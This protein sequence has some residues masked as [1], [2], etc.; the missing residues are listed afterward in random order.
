MIRFVDIRSQGTG[1]R[2][3]FWDTTR[4]QFCTFANDQAWETRK[5]FIESFD[6]SGGNF[7]DAVSV[8]G[9]DRFNNLMPDWTDIDPT[10][11][12]L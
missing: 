8:S 7:A 4:D 11:D 9:F 6:L 10:E 5:D 2:F 12:E 1:Y 3:A